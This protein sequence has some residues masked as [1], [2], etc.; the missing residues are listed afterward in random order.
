MAVAVRRRV[1]FVRSKVE[2]RRILVPL[3]GEAGLGRTMTNACRLA[4]ERGASVTAV[5]VVEVPSELPLDAHMVEEEAH[6]KRL[7]TEAE[8]IGDA[9]GVTVVPLVVRARSAGHAIVEEAERSGAEIIVLRAAQRRRARKR[10]PLFGS[11]TGFILQNAPCR[12][13]VSAPAPV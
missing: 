9:H 11:T 13:M 4:A 10:G 8:A 6:A 3:A 1:P 5:S 2:Y 12:V 7:V